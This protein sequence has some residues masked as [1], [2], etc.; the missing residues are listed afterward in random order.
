M[1]DTV[2][3]KEYIGKLSYTQS[4]KICKTQSMVFKDT[5]LPPIFYYGVPQNDIVKDSDVYTRKL[6]KSALNTLL[7]EKGYNG[8]GKMIFN[9]AIKGSKHVDP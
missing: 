6:D 3:T 9:M 1:R 5:D 8:E 4:L 7:E 2:L